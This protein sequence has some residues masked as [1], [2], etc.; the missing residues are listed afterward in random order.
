M[1]NLKRQYRALAAEYRQLERQRKK[2]LDEQGSLADEIERIK[3]S[4]PGIFSRMRLERLLDRNLEVSRGLDEIARKIAGNERRRIA[5]RKKVYQAYTSELE[6]V[7]ELLK[8][9]NN[10][11]LAAD[12]ARR[13]YELRRRR[14]K[15][16]SPT[17]V[18]TD[19]SMFEVES[20][21]LNT[22]D[23]LRGRA[24]LLDDIVVKIREAIKRIDQ[25][26]ERLG[27][28][29]R[30]TR[31]MH[32]MVRQMNLF[33]EGTRFHTG[34]RTMPRSVEPT[35]EEQV[36]PEEESSA[37]IPPLAS[38]QGGV[39]GADRVTSSIQQEIDQLEK[40][41]EYLVTLAAE[42]S[43][44]AAELRK[45]AKQMDRRDNLPRPPATRRIRPGNE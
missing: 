42:L 40:E 31:E 43:S 29:L 3:S 41:R 36:E 17:T 20:G 2:L 9:T 1:V 18:E 28:E 8:Q 32:E 39:P 16:R 21:S 35:P 26:I 7:V 23:E 34:D 27:R 10:K 38:D 22:A 45:K 24:D 6:R 13:F 14:Q 30:L 19:F 33:E 12:Y 44:R 4:E 15:W 25:T 37:H 11:K 5:L